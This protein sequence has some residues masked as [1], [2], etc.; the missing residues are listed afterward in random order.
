MDFL[1]RCAAHSG[2]PLPVLP[3][4]GHTRNQRE[5]L[6]HTT[7]SKAEDQGKMAA[8][9]ESRKH[10]EALSSY[11][12]HSP[13]QQSEP[14]S[15]H[16]WQSPRVSLELTAQTEP[17]E[18]PVAR[19]PR[20]ESCRLRTNANAVPPSSHL[21]LLLFAS[22]PTRVC[23]Q[24]AIRPAWVKL[25]TQH[26]W[27]QISRVVLE[28]ASEPCT[29][30]HDLRLRAL[31]S[32][33]CKADPCLSSSCPSDFLSSL[34]VESKVCLSTGHLHGNYDSSERP[35]PLW[36]LSR[37]CA[38]SLPRSPWDRL[39]SHPLAREITSLLL[40]AP[41]GICSRELLAGI[42]SRFSTLARTQS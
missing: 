19:S 14:Q 39:P 11:R 29:R 38:R 30:H 7:P 25:F 13:R 21:P 31:K 41:G 15:V 20:R 12:F 26:S 3:S 9:D 28:W 1:G 5:R 8:G 33:S 35:S 6:P 34:S 10:S 36:R 23:H 18:L 17:G 24:Q 40:R 2:R 37:T 27:V 42:H 4:V 32:L 22:F 16:D